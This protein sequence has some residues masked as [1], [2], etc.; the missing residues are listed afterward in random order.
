MIL[1]PDVLRFTFILMGNTFIT[2]FL[3]GMLTYFTGNEI[4][5]G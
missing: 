5:V 1:K 4:A 2:T 3:P